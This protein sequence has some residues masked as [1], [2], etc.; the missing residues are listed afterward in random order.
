MAHLEATRRDLLGG[1][2]AVPALALSIASEPAQAVEVPPDDDDPQEAYANGLDVAHTDF[3]LAWLQ[4]WTAAGGTVTKD[5]SE[6]D[7]VWIGMPVFDRSAEYPEY[8]QR[9]TDMR[10]AEWFLAQ[11]KSQQQAQ[12]RDNYLLYSYRYDG[13]MRGLYDFICASPR[14]LDYVKRLVA[15]D[16]R[17][18]LSVR[19]EA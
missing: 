9:L 3:A 6:P 11:P 17:I 5:Y 16:R 15:I 8:E 14:V 12:E 13:K 1:I 18:G 4:Q 10:S 19:R 7:K 2:V